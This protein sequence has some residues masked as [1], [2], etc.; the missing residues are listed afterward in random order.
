LGELFFEEPGSEKYVATKIYEIIHEDVPNKPKLKQ[1]YPE[2]ISAPKPDV[3][4]R[5]MPATPMD[6]TRAGLITASDTD[7]MVAVNTVSQKYQIKP[8]DLL[9]VMYRESALDPAAVNKSSG[10]TGLIQFMPKTAESLGTTTSAL[11]M[12]NRAGQMQF[13]DKYFEQVGLPKGAD[14]GTIY[15]YVFL[16]GIAAKGTNTLASVNDPNTKKYYDAN[17]GLDKNNDGLITIDDLRQA[18]SS[19]PNIPTNPVAAAPPSSK[20]AEVP[21]A[22][23]KSTDEQTQVTAAAAAQAVPIL[24]GQIDAVAKAANDRMNNIELATFNS[25]K[26]P[27]A[28]NLDPS[29]KNY[30]LNG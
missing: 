12:M 21:T 11:R 4:P 20:P 28:V 10:A 7:F 25:R 2:D 3:Q 1:E 8:E 26:N 16:P 30:I 6:R 18:T 14:R 24:R 15:A 19:M 27:G 5:D 29:L 17:R 23:N 9:A 22:A 13:V